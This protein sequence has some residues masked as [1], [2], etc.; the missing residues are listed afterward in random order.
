MKYYKETLENIQTASNLAYRLSRPQQV[1]ETVTDQT[2]YS[3]GWITH[4]DG[5]EWAATIP[6]DLDLP[7]HQFIKDSVAN[8][9][10]VS[11]LFD[12][13][14]ATQ[15]EADTKKQLVVDS[16]R[17]SVLDIIP[18]SWVETSKADLEANGW[19]PVEEMP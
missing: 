4:P 16:A 8:G 5:N 18:D 6:E 2:Q 14:Y 12:S 3:F 11:A 1:P 7:I 15:E 17:V 9:N 19:F 13:F 10:E